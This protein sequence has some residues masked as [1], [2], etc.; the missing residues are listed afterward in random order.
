M[1]SSRFWE[2]SKENWATESISYLSL[3][4]DVRGSVSH[5][6]KFK[7]TQGHVDGPAISELSGQVLSHR[8]LHDFLLVVLEDLFEMRRELFPVSILDKETLCT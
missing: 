2:K 1:W 6:I 5:L 3:G 4:I 7:R 8:A